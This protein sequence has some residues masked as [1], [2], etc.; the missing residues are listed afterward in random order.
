MQR[1]F[2]KENRLLDTP[3]GLLPRILLLGAVV[4][5]VISFISP[6]WTMTMYAPQYQEGL[7][8]FIHSYKLDGGNEG[9]DVKEIN[10]LNHYIGMR[11]IVSTDF[12]EFKW[13]PFVIG[14]IALLILRTAVIGRMMQI[15]DVAV[16]YAYFGLFAL[17]SFGY[18]LYSY[19]HTLERGAAVQVEPFTP[20]MFG[21]KQIANFEVY[22]YP[23]LGG[24]MLAGA[25]LVLFVA[26]FM[27]WRQRRAW[28]V[29][30]ANPV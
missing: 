7:R 19:G 29:A 18:K 5:L 9:Q 20:P 25:A 2:V 11:D 16:L 28:S 13:M 17:W 1:I 23:G 24:Y 27:A 3:I 4:M 14:G 26:L 6:L 22:S 15:I 30:E 10:I 12:T 21:F 8:L